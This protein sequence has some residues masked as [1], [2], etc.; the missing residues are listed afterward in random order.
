MVNNVPEGTVG[1]AKIVEC[2]QRPAASYDERAEVW[3]FFQQNTLRCRFFLRIPVVTGCAE[4]EL[5]HPRNRQ[6]RTMNNLSY[7]REINSL[8][9]FLLLGLGNSFF[10]GVFMLLF[11]LPETFDCVDLGLSIDLRVVR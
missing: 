8:W 11:H 3:R 6:Q 5:G 1:L 10:D 4:D 9:I 2:E 7:E